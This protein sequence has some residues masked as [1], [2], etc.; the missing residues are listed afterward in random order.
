MLNIDNRYLNAEQIDAIGKTAIGKSFKEIANGA[1]INEASKGGL[2]NFIENNLF[3]FQ[4][5]IFAKL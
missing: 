4:H 2:G 5:L 3:H 1:E